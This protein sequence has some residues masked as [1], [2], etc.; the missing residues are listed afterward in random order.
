MKNSKNLGIWMD[1]SVAHLMALTGE[2]VE[3]TTIKSDFSHEEKEGA[4]NRSEHVMHNK[5]N[6][7][8]AEFYKNISKI[9]QNY[10]AVLLFGPTKAKNELLNILEEDQLCANIKIEVKSAEKMTENQQHAFVKEY[11][12]S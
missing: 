3:T 7:R 10:D 11:F 8:Q 4:L 1:H 2:T 9:I 6:Q 12:K 5:E